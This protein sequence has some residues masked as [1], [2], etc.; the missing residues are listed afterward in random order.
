MRVAG[1]GADNLDTALVPWFTG[2][3]A[4]TPTAHDN[5]G[6]GMARAVAVARALK[7]AGVD[8]GWTIVPLSAG[9]FLKPNDQVTDGKRKG[10]DEAERRIEI[11]LRRPR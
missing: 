9:P 6:L 4:M 2:A 3:S 10:A 7:A 5:V 1:L 11:R 8:K